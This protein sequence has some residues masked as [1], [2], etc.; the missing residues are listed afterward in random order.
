[1]KYNSDDE[2][3]IVY[4]IYILFL[5]PSI[6]DLLRGTPSP[7]G[8][9]K[10]KWATPAIHIEA[11]TKSLVEEVSIILLPYKMENNCASLAYISCLWNKVTPK[12]M[13]GE[14]IESIVKEKH[15]SIKG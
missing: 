6:V 11:K 14:C 10:K 4:L 5:K 8:I 15:C 13:N 2:V 3:L 7:L 12:L 1:M 9:R